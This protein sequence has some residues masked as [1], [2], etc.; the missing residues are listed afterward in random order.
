MTQGDGADRRCSGSPRLHTAGPDRRSARHL[1]AGRVVAALAGALLVASCQLTRLPGPPAGSEAGPD[2]GQPRVRIETG[3]LASAT[4]CTLTYDL[5]HAGAG[6]A[7]A[8]VVLAHGFLRSKER[9]AGLATALADAGLVTVAVDL[10]NMR[11]WDGA[12]RQNAADLRRIAA[13]LGGDAVLYAGFSAGGLAALLAATADRHSVGAVVLDLVDQDRLGEDAAAVL[14]RPLVGLVGESSRCNADNNGL[15]VFAAAA[16]AETIRFDGATHC[17]FE[18][19]SD[20]L[21]RLI[22]E[23]GGRDRR[24][25]AQTRAAIIAAAVEAA[26]RLLRDAPRAASVTGGD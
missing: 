21:C 16:T 2:G 15:A 1:C 23:P 14:A 19:P 26:R 9:M 18:S 6:P 3:G 20:R 25:S 12:H 7:A 11:P 24:R 13:R 10:C 8:Q 22:C 5:Y 4:G 17:D